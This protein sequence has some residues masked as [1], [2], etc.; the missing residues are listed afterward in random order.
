MHGPQDIL[1][2]RWA[3]PSGQTRYLHD[4]LRHGTATQKESF[5][6]R[7]ASSGCRIAQVAIFTATT[8]NDWQ[9]EGNL[10]FATGYQLADKLAASRHSHNGRCESRQ[11]T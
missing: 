7:G 2:L 8:N 5:A 9:R 3:P 4:W 10:Q 6:R 1:T 11:S